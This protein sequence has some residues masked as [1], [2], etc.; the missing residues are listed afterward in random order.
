MGQLLSFYRAAV[1][2]TVRLQ[3][4]GIIAN[5]QLF[6]GPFQSFEEANHWEACFLENKAQKQCFYYNQE[7]QSFPCEQIIAECTVFESSVTSYD[8]ELMTPL[9]KPV[10]PDVFSAHLVLRTLR[11]VME[12][13]TDTTDHLS[14]FSRSIF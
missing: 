5:I 13:I 1:S 14:L 4:P 11:A 3:L 12:K 9:V 2:L 10:D 7:E 8:P 6:I